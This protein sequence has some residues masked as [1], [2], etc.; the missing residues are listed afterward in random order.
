MAE[1]VGGGRIGP[2]TWPASSRLPLIFFPLLAAATV[3]G[4]SSAPVSA[5]HAL[6]RYLAAAALR[7]RLREIGMA[8]GA[9]WPPV[10][11]FRRTADTALVVDGS[12]ADRNHSYWKRPSVL[13]LSARRE[14]YGIGAGCAYGDQF[15][16]RAAG[17]LSE[18]F[19]DRIAPTKDGSAG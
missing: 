9:L 2:P 8:R 5:A 6:T 18:Q 14:T 13:G 7:R 1:G 16:V 4:R 3:L 10:P 15:V 11:T 17:A 19:R 12:M